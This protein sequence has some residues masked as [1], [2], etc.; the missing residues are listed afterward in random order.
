MK[1]DNLRVNV[2]WIGS[3]IDAD[4]GETKSTRNWS[5]FH[6]K[7]TVDRRRVKREVRKAMGKI[8][9]RTLHTYELLL[10]VRTKRFT[11]DGL[12]TVDAFASRFGEDQAPEEA[13]RLMPA[14][15]GPDGDGGE[16][17][18][19]RSLDGADTSGATPE[20]QRDGREDSNG[21]PQGFVQRVHDE[22]GGLLTLGGGL[23]ADGATPGNTS[24][25]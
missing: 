5:R 2:P 10:A 13:A 19:P 4:T 24:I 23:V 11:H 17:A 7:G 6:F 16:R 18:R 15:F 20:L 21:S 25:A 1:Y 14:M 22:T 9:E 3:D 8:L 12:D